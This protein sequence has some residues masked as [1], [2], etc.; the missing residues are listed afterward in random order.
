MG[1]ILVR[2]IYW[3]KKKMVSQVSNLLKRPTERVTIACDIMYLSGIHRSH[4]TKLVLVFLPQSFDLKLPILCMLCLQQWLPVG[5]CNQYLSSL[6]TKFANSAKM[7][8][9]PPPRGDHTI[10][11]SF[12]NKSCTSHPHECKNVYFFFM[13][14]ILFF[15]QES[16]GFLRGLFSQLSSAGGEV[17][18]TQH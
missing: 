12:E 15:C 3:G 5:Q 17:T 2:G 16:S 10:H 8:S 1:G 9:P 13:N 7:V 4:R 11:G 6:R 14:C 18:S